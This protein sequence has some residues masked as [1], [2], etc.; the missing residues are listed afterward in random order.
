MTREDFNKL[1]GLPESQAHKWFPHIAGAMR[2]FGIV[3]KKDKALFL[4]FV[5]S[6]SR[7]LT[8][9]VDNM[10]Y[11]VTELKSY[12][13]GR[14]TKYQAEMLGA[15]VY[16]PARPDAIANLVYAHF[17]GNFEHHDGW[18]YRPRGLLPIVGRNRY[19]ECGLALGI[20]LISSPEKLE[21]PCYAALSAAW[22]WVWSRCQR[23]S[24]IDVIANILSDGPQRELPLN[25]Y[26]TAMKTL[27]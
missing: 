2:Y 10:E 24:S 1:S 20:D 5:L 4:S 8:R 26:A 23:H 12:F 22:L 15:D 19:G 14:I 7:L 11:T 9:L 13:T 3:E 17:N 16:H 27:K 6:E 18:T 25:F 21:E